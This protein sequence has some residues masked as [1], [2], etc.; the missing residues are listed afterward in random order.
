ME[1]VARLTAVRRTRMTV[2]ARREQLLDATAEIV[3]ER[4]FAA[5]SIQAVA[6]RAGISRPIVYEHFGGLQGLLEALVKREMGRAVAQ[7]AETELAD[8]SKG[9]PNELML[10]S[11]GSY[12]AAVEA[13]PTT[14]RLVLTAP[15][16]A[17]ELLRKRI[18][19][20][21]AAVLKSITNA[22]RPG[23]LAG[24]RSQDPEVTARI[25]SAMADEYARLVLSDPVRFAPQRL[26][27]HARWW[28]R[29]SES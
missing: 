2:P 24:D 26:L 19:R 15:E 11:L 14:W 17:P 10:E 7:V 12:L 23:S 1:L 29:H 3:G 20:G 28:L 13:N 5:V 16:G 27:E 18:L 25:L 9:D 6:R 4:G 8:L 22:V 21:R